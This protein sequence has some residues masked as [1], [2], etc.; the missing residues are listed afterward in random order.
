MPPGRPDLPVV[1]IWYVAPPLAGLGLLV[2]FLLRG[3]NEQAA[4]LGVVLLLSLPLLVY[5]YRRDFPRKRG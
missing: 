5:A 2:A 4:L 3:D 1:T